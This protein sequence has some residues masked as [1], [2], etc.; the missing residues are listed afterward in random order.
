MSALMSFN[1]EPFEAEFLAGLLEAETGET[2]AFEA[3]EENESRRGRAPRRAPRKFAPRPRPPKR[4]RLSDGG[5]SFAPFPVAFAPAPPVEEPFEPLDDAPADDAAADGGP[6]DELA[7]SKRRRGAPA[8][9]WAARL[10]PM[11]RRAAPEIPLDFLLGW[12]AVESGGDI[13]SLTR[14][15]ERGF[16]QLHPEESRTL[17]LDHRRLSSDPDY[18]IQGGVALVRHYAARAR[19]LGFAPGTDL[20]WRIVKLLHWLP[21]GVRTTLA[22]MRRNGFSARDWPSFRAYMIT[23][24]DELLTQL[25]AKAG[26]GWDPASGVRNVDALFTRGRAL[27]SGLATPA[28]ATA[29]SAPSPAGPRAVAPR[30]SPV[31]APRPITTHDAY[32]PPRFLDQP[33]TPPVAPDIFTPQGAPGRRTPTP[34]S[35]PRGARAAPAPAFDP[36]AFR[37]RLVEVALQ[38]LARWDNGKMLETEARA[39]ATLQDYWKT[40]VGRSYSL[41]QLAN[42]SFQ[43]ATPWSAAFISWTVR[44]AGAGNLFRYSAAHAEYVRAAI[45]ARK[46]NSANPIK[47]YRI[48]ELAPLPGD[49]LGRARDSS[50]ATYDNVRSGMAMHS[51]IVV[52]VGPTHVDVVGGNVGAGTVGRRRWRL[53]NGRVAEGKYFVLIRAGAAQPT[54]PA[55]PP[56]AR[57]APAPRPTPAPTPPPSGPA[58]K[59]VKRD[60]VAQ[61]ETLYFSVDLKIPGAPARTGVFVPKGF[62]PGVGV[63][64]VLWLHGWKDPSL[65]APAIEQYWNAAR[66]PHFALRE[67]VAASGRN[68]VLIAPTL[69][70]TSQPGA[71]IT[72]GAL[73]AYLAQVLAGLRAQGPWRD[74]P[75]AP[76]LQN[77]VLACHSGGGKVMRELAGGRD[78]AAAL[79]RECWG[80]DC[81]YSSADPGFWSKFGKSRPGAKVA[82]YYIAGSKTA[83]FAEALKKVAPAN[84]MVQPSRETRHNWV[85]IAY[86]ED[87]LRRAAFLA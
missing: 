46:S 87:R 34:S 77:L 42:K 18:S 63:D 16:F 86:F 68:L 6:D 26:A 60:Q 10:A 58:P 49:I 59:L 82:I 43:R 14:L 45:A 52:A 21:R 32:A 51:D 9:A 85:P 29:P 33:F 22:H 55:A 71:L 19:K 7:G 76:V 67:A 69:G 64:V 13:A 80:F 17:R 2:E 54:A 24:R 73:D 48:T 75:A 62:K 57:P 78:R 30:R 47:G 72:P 79:V 61:G 31:T 37:A 28:P 84:V 8:T 50:G 65:A 5:R 35:A 11:L 83:T 40:G 12:I 81:T 1:P 20:F 56:P 3:E 23:H 27:A 53:V 36:V 4:A 44:K 25:V 41:A 38:E 15:D 74:A 70:P 39:G 66:F